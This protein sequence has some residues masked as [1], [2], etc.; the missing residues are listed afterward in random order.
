[1]KKLVFCLSILV[2]YLLPS[3]AMDPGRYNY[4]YDELFEEVIRVELVQYE[5]SEQKHFKSWVP[6]HFSD[7]VSFLPQNMKIVETLE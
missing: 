3:C 4:D 2:I 7:L 1:M 5:N 6:N